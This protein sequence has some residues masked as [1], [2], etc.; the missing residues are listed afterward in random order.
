MIEVGEGEDG[1]EGNGR[2]LSRMKEAEDESS[3]TF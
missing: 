2:L 1:M 3:L